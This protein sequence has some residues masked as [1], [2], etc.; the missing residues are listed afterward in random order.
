MASAAAPSEPQD[1]K[2]GPT[3]L[4]PQQ[5]PNGGLGPHVSA[6]LNAVRRA[7]NS[8]RVYLAVGAVVAVVAGSTFGQ[9]RLNLW[10]RDFYD[11]LAGRNV[12]GFLTQLLVF[13]AV[14]ALLLSFGVAQVWLRETLKKIGRA[15]V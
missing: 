5:Q 3:G 14:V 1:R 12:D 9:L 15:H 13:A 4:K 7:H 8:R 6:F 11:A 10:Q 2:V